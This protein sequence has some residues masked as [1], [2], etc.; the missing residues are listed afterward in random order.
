MRII[1]K[2]FSGT[3]EGISSAGLSEVE[4]ISRVS[5]YQT[6][7]VEEES[8]VPDFILYQNYPN[9][10]NPSTKIKFSVSGLKAGFVV[11][12]IYDIA[13]REVAL[14]VNGKIASGEHELTFDGSGLPSGV[15]FARLTAGNK[16]S[17][18]RMFLIK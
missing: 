4:T 3:I 5:V 15:Y 7:V 10:F 9:P 8:A 18:R 12:K 2:S 17:V 11:L 6:G 14:L 13:G 16:T 1:I